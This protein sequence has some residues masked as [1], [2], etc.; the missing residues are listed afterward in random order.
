[1]EFV[2][3]PSPHPLFLRSLELRKKYFCDC[4]SSDFPPPPLSLSPPPEKGFPKGVY[5]ST[6]IPSSRSP[7][8]GGCSRARRPGSGR[9][10]RGRAAER[11]R[12]SPRTAHTTPRPDKV[13]ELVGRR[14]REL[15]HGM[16]VTPPLG[17]ETRRVLSTR[18]A[19]SMD[20]DRTTQAQRE[21]RDKNGVQLHVHV[22]TER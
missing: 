21:M 3:L 15:G 7:R 6:R 1:M 11:C 20:A 8:C 9:C 12:P 22:G 19:G 4:L 14:R 10:R 2:L 17:V 18:G 5:C 13:R 16:G